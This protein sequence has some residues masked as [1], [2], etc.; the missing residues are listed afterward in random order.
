MLPSRFTRSSDRLTI[1]G[2]RLTDVDDYVASIDDE[3]MG[4]Q[5]F[6]V[7]EADRRRA[8]IRHAVR[9]RVN[10]YP[11]TIAVCD[12][13]TG[14]FVGVY[15]V[16]SHDRSFRLRDTSP[17]LGWWLAAH[18]RGNGLGTESLAL[19]LDHLHLTA[20]VRRVV[21]GTDI[22]NRRAIAQI[23][24]VGASGTGTS[25]YR[26]PDGLEVPSVWYQHVRRVGDRFRLPDPPVGPPTGSSG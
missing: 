22:R 10:Y 21:M 16:Q 11:A 2:L 1:R 14:S 4:W 20:A 5:G 12:R 26:R 25:L 8:T 19:V 18:A 23:E 9:N 17:R 3:V 24:R 13:S 6:P 15:L 7:G